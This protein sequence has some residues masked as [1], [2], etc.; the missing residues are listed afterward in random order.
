MPELS[1]ILKISEIYK[2]L[3]FYDKKTNTDRNILLQL[4]RT[5]VTRN[6]FG[7]KIMNLHFYTIIKKNSFISK[8]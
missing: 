4:R 3:G 8:Q 6:R 2:S 7:Y 5:I 1:R